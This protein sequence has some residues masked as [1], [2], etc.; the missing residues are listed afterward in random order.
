[1]T[2]FHTSTIAERG[3]PGID[4][5]QHLDRCRQVPP[6]QVPTQLKVDVSPLRWE[7][8]QECLSVGS[9]M[10]SEL[11]SI[12]AGISA[13]QSRRTCAQPWSMQTWSGSI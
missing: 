2:G 6:P 3:Y 5:L 12:T 4:D 11:A 8:W 10:V 13:G 9:E 7:V 1:M